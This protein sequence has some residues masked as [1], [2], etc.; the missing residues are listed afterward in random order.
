MR[1]HMIFSTN[2]TCYY[3]WVW[4]QACHNEGRAETE[5]RMLRAT[6]GPETK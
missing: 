6:F 5:N 4:S 3:V 2:N 1:K